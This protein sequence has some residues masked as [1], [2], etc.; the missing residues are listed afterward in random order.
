[1]GHYKAVL[2]TSNHNGSGNIDEKPLS[3]LYKEFSFC[4]AVFLIDAKA[5]I[6]P[7]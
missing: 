5:I 7:L 6:C 1:M 4:E 2:I 3:S